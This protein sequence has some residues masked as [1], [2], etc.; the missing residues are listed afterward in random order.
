MND[1]VVSIEEKAFRRNGTATSVLKDIAFSVPAGS[2]VCLYG[3]SGCGKT[4]LLRIIAGLETAFRGE[5]NLGAKL[6]TQPTKDIGLTVQTHV[7]YDWLTVAGNIAFGLRYTPQVQATLR[8]RLFGRMNQTV[9]AQE[10]ERLAAIVGLSHADLSKYPEE[11]SGGM[12]QR[13]A[14]A[15]ALLPNPQVLLLDEPFSSLDFESRQALQDVVLRIRDKLGT[16]FLCVSHDPEEVLYL[17]DEVLIFHGA[18][19]KIV[20]RLRPHLPYHGSSEK[21]YTQEFQAAKKELYGWLNYSTAAPK[22]Q[23]HDSC[24][25]REMTSHHC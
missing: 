17:A 3:P 20:H 25:P 16:T 7:S 24:P 14:F 12:K 11:I 13:M 1:L 15:R 19:A 5:V 22:T 8:G 9:A 6:I 2:I 21:R 4:T 10:A 18:P 23:P